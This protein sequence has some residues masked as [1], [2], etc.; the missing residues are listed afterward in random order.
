MLGNS[1]AR[2]NACTC[3]RPAL[4]K[5]CLLHYYSPYDYGH[6]IGL[7]KNGKVETIIVHMIIATTGWRRMERW[8]L[9]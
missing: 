1:T 7:E 6:N 9:L 8:R 5:T 2:T 3:D 4:S